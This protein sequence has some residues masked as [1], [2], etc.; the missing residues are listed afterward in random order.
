MLNTTAPLDW[1]RRD[2]RDVHAV[3]R[4]APLETLYIRVRIGMVDHTNNQE[5][6]VTITHTPS[7][8]EL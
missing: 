1:L 2:A 3:P 5:R 4:Q 7:G 8:E 6:G